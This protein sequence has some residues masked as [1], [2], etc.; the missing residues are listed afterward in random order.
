[1]QRVSSSTAATRHS[2]LATSH[3]SELRVVAFLGQAGWRRHPFLDVCEVRGSE[4][5]LCI[6][7]CSQVFRCA[8]S[9]TSEG[10]VCASPR[11]VV[12]KEK[13]NRDA[14]EVSSF[15]KSRHSRAS[16]NPPNL[17][18]RFRRDDIMLFLNGKSVMLHQ[19]GWRAKLC[20]LRALQRRSQKTRTAKSAVR[21]TCLL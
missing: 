18:P 7:Q 19:R 16:G 11:I 4:P 20:G 3:S 14:L 9:Q 1:M 21:A 13:E 2:A 12:E 10:E 15:P 17:G 6:G 8:K 5:K